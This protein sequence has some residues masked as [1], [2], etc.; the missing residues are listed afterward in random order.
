MPLKRTYLDNRLLTIKGAP[1]VL[2]TRCAR[3][4]D[5]DGTSKVLDDGMMANFSRTK[6]QWSSQGK[7]VI[8]LARKIVRKAEILSSPQAT[9]FEREI[10][11]HAKSDLTLVGLVGIVD[12]PRDE[13]PSVVETLRSAGIR[14]F[15][16]RYDANWDP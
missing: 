13:I 9:Q 4:V 3:F 14:L 6:D 12:P 16:V 1:D 7:R 8:L 11:D 5:R 15:M 10:M 2:I